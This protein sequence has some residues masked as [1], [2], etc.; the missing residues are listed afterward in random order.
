MLRCLSSFQDTF[1]ISSYIDSDDLVK[2][3][4]HLCDGLVVGHLA[5]QLAMH[6]LYP[7]GIIDRTRILNRILN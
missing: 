7:D 4:G 3:H 1:S 2:F 5:L 6:E